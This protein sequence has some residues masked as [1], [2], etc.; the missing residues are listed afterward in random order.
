MNNVYAD[1]TN[2][3]KFLT[4]FL[5]SNGCVNEHN[6]AD[7]RYFIPKIHVYKES[8]KKKKIHVAIA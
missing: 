2:Q 8:K 3:F 5:D 4:V 6:I 1:I 7:S